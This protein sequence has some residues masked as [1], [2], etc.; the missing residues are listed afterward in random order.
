VGKADHY[1]VLGVGRDASFEE[2]KGAY[3]REALRWHPDRHPENGEAEERFKAAAS[4]YEVLRDPERRRRHDME[5]AGLGQ[6]P[7][8]AR[9]GGRRGCGRGRGRR[10]RGGFGRGRPSACAR[11]HVQAGGRWARARQGFGGGPL[12]DISLGPIE[13]ALGCRRR[14]A[15]ESVSGTQVVDVRFPAGL[16]DGDV[17]RLDGLQEGL[18][19]RVNIL[20]AV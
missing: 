14:V 5:L 7:A 11:E 12:V 8:F 6:E 13:A 16:A 15:L 10:S 9:Y 19:L 4:A 20:P 2:I 18:C 17:V 1:K 3:R